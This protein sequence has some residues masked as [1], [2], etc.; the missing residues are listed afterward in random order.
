VVW[1]RRLAALLCGVGLLTAGCSDSEGEQPPPV[2]T[3]V[4]ADT[5]G[6]ADLYDD[7]Y[8]VDARTGARRNLTRT[9]RRAEMLP[10]ASPD[11]VRIA[12]YASAPQDLQVLDLRTNARRRLASGADLA[13]DV[14]RAPPSWSPDGSRIAFGVTTGCEAFEECEK[15]EI[16]IVRAAG[17]RPAR[18]SRDGRVAT[19]SPDGG[20][21]AWWG[22]IKLEGYGSRAIVWDAGTGRQRDVGRSESPPV[23]LPDQTLLAGGRVHDLASGQS[24]RARPTDYGLRSPDGSHVALIGGLS[25]EEL[26]VTRIRGGGRFRVGEVLAQAW[27][28]DGGELAFVEAKTGMPVSVVN[29]D[30]S[31]RREL[32]RE[33]HE[34]QTSSPLVWAANNLLVYSGHLRLQDTELLAVAPDGGRREQLTRND[35]SEFEPAVSPDGG[36]IAFVRGYHDQIWSMRGDGSAALRLAGNRE[37]RAFSPVWSPDGDELAFVRSDTRAVNDEGSPPDLFVM[38]RDGSSVRQLTRDAWATDP[39]WSPDG[40]RIA[41]TRSQRECRAIWLMAPDGE[42]DQRLTDCDFYAAAPA[43]AP[44]GEELAF[45]GRPVAELDFRHFLHLYVLDADGGDPRLVAH[46]AQMLQPSGLA[47]DEP[48]YEAPSWSPDGRRLV[49]SR[50]RGFQR[51]GLYVVD[52]D[53]GHPVSIDRDGRDPFW[54]VLLSARE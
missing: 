45:L 9:L 25:D 16:W 10:S 4:F 15:A 3:I 23:W 29:A 2:G 43:W 6:K 32:R 11:G 48:L 34:F 54:A 17:G 40:K 8:A 38:R 24:R 14:P 47:N 53:G 44:D 22:G 5:V 41:Y 39:A 31:G 49:Y 1:R 7:L 37:L 52:V 21:L 19:W 50:K 20:Q 30:G 36:R 28:P 33:H 26:R 12:F 51:L 13:F 18:V 46:D 35:L 27:S 42:E